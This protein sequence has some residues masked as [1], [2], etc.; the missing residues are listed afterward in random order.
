MAKED[1]LKVEEDIIEFIKKIEMNFNMPIDI[2]F[3][4]LINRKL[5]QLVKFVKIPDLYSNNISLNSD[6]MII[7]ND[8]YFD[9]FDDDTKKILI[10][11]EFDRIEFNF[12][13]G[14]I[15]LVTPKINVNNGFVE[16]YSWETI[17]NALK[18][19]Q[20]FEQQRKDKENDKKE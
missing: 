7:I 14:T 3:K 19:E 9:N 10:E 5:K 16:K 20:E 12:E 8:D 11:K 13:K 1:Y 18:L 4:Y 6:I 15:K 17:S 2:S